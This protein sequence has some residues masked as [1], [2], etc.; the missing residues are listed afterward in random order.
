MHAGN[1]PVQIVGKECL[2]CRQG[3]LCT[4]FTAEHDQL[5]SMC[6]ALP[7]F[8]SRCLIQGVACL[9]LPPLLM[10][11]L[12]RVFQQPLPTFS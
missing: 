9:Q 8:H 6:L 4:R 2:P 1:A 10:L 5:L 12:L 3:M 11:M 7:L